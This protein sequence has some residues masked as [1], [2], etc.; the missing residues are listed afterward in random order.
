MA[1]IPLLFRLE[2]DP[3]QYQVT[4]NLLR[5]VWSFSSPQAVP[6]SKAASCFYHYENLLTD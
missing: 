3:Q 1:K 5:G 6:K 4:Q 2:E